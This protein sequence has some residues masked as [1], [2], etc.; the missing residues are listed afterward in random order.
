MTKQPPGRHY[1]GCSIENSEF[2]VSERV[3]VNPNNSLA[4]CVNLLFKTITKFSNA[5]G[6]QQPYLSI[7]WTVAHV[8]LV[9][10]QHAPFCA[11]CC[12]ALNLLSKLLGFSAFITTF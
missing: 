5:I 12:G 6:Y 4:E 10:G 2:I 8:M 7:T 3:Q 9:I 1:R 11:R